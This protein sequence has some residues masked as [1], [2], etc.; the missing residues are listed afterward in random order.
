MKRNYNSY[1]DQSSF[2][3]TLS[4]RYHKINPIG[5]QEIDLALDEYCKLRHLSNNTKTQLKKSLYKRLIVN[6]FGCYN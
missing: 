6:E 3:N 4:N 1:V 5:E 2:S